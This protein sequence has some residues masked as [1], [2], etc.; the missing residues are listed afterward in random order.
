[1]A[2]LLQV[3]VLLLALAAVYRPLGDY[4]ARVFTD[5]RHLAVERAVYRVVRANP[6]AGQR[7]PVYA[8]G[9]LGFSLVSIVSLYLLQRLQPLLP[10]GFGRGPVD[11]GTAFN[12][13]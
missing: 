7:W 11:P 8:A 1:M 2:G 6:E 4:M 5:T 13:Y 3:G 10:F 12:S 9:V